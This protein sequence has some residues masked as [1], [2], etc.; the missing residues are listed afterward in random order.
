MFGFVRPVRLTDESPK[1]A[2]TMPPR[3]LAFTIAASLLLL[4]Y[5]A[6]RVSGHGG[7][8]RGVDGRPS[9]SKAQWWI[10][11][12]VV[13]F[14]YVAVFVERWLRGNP[15]AGIEVPQN[16]L[17]AMGF[18]GATMAG[19]KAITGAH[20][21]RLLVNKMKTSTDVGGILS[22]DEGAPDLSKIQNVAFTVIAVFVYLVRLGTQGDG[23]TLPEMVDI[24]PSI[25]LL[26]GLSHGGYLAA[27]I[28]PPGN[29]EL[30]R[31]K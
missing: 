4:L 23:H 11:T 6:T 17:L 18:S 5:L 3:V 25:M 21:A 14:G 10:W 31:S 29:A 28:A 27:K 20:V 16:L 30:A 7:L 19:A 12:A 15:S 22:D 24:D 26:M 8:V 13:I 2:M 1:E 9:T